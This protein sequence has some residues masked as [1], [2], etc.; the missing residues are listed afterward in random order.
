MQEEVTLG[1][2]SA[3]GHLGLATQYG[4]TTEIES[5]SLV[6]LIDLHQTMKLQSSKDLAGML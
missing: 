1:A 5:K 6:R 4:S 2:A 3:A